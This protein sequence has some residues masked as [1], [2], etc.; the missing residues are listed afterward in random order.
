MSDAETNDTDWNAVSDVLTSKYRQTAL[1]KLVEGPATP[2][3]VANR[4][5]DDENAGVFSKALRQLEDMGLVELLVDE[6]KKRGRLYGLTPKGED[7]AE[8]MSEVT[9]R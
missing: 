4:V 2:S 8:S 6:D 1:E 7:V 9:G 3:T 5:G